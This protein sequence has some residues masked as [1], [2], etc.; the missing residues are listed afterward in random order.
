MGDFLFVFEHY[1][2]QAL[3]IVGQLELVGDLSNHNKLF[4]EAVQEFVLIDF[5]RDYFLHK[6]IK[7]SDI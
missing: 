2:H 1:Q 4:S 6:A 5:L 3:S 7:I